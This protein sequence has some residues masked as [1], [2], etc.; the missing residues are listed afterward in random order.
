MR[1]INQMM[2][3]IFHSNPKI[4]AK[5]KRCFKC[6]QSKPLSHFYKHPE[7]K[8]GHLNKCK[9]CTKID[10]RA[11]FKDNKSYYKQYEKKRGQTPER[12][13]NKRIYEDTHKVNNPD[14]YKAR[15]AVGNAIRD[16]RS[17]RKSCRVCG[18]KAEAHHVDY[19]KPLDVDWL[20]RTHHREEHKKQ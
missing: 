4:R 17:I 3:Q 2:K 5:Y 20:C 15:T 6:G 10:V 12:K 9:E 1:N 11:N 7:M 18:K 13:A 19:S 8:D 14:K 16:G